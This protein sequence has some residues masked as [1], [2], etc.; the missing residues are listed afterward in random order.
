MTELNNNAALNTTIAVAAVASLWTLGRL[1]VRHIDGQPLVPYEPRRPVPWNGWPALLLLAP[2][3]LSVGARVVGYAAPADE[4]F[5]AWEV[6]GAALLAQVAAASAQVA[7]VATTATNALAPVVKIAV[8]AAGAAERAGDFVLAAVASTA[9]Q[10]LIAA[11]TYAALATFTGATRRDLGLPADVRQF[12]SDVRLGGIAFLAALAP[13]YLVQAVLTWAFEPQEGHPFV[14]E[15]V[16]NPSWGVMGAIALA[17]VVA[18]PVFEETAFRLVLL[19]WLDKL[20]RRPPM[21]ERGVEWLGT[22]PSE[23]PSASLLE[24][25]AEDAVA[26]VANSGDNAGAADISPAWWPI[27]VT[28]VLFGLAHWGHGAAPA[29]LMLLGLVLGYLYHRTGRIVPSMTC[30]LFFN[31]FTMW[32]LLLLFLG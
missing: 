18:A 6:A 28:A 31:A 27:A 25:P 8:S 15:F 11:L 10:L 26:G 3:I 30:H 7:A 5:E 16:A 9:V 20:Q 17:A 32:Q 2:L 24:S 1:F 13:V 12:R 21:P 23:A 19:G 22:Q 29:P 14:M 4:S